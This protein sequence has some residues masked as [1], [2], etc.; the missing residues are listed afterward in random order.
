MPFYAILSVLL[1]TL[2]SLLHNLHRLCLLEATDR[3]GAKI[4]MDSGN[5]GLLS[6]A[7]ATFYGSIRIRLREEP[8]P[9]ISLTREEYESANTSHPPGPLPH[10]VKAAALAA[11]KQL[12]GHYF[13]SDRD[14]KIPLYLFIRWVVLST[15]LRS[16]FDPATPTNI[17]HTAWDVIGT[18]PM[19]DWRGSPLSKLIEPSQNPSGVFALLSTPERL[20]LVAICTEGR[21]LEFLRQARDLLAHPT[22]PESEVIRLVEGIRRSIQPI[23]F[24]HDRRPVGS[25]LFQNRAHEMD[26]RIPVGFLPPSDC[27]QDQDGS[28]I[29]WL[30]KAQPGQL[31]CGGE[32]WLVHATAI[33]LSAIVTGIRDRN[34]AVDGDD[35][36]AWEDRVLRKSRV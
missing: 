12:I 25:L 2:L 13:G 22:S 33:T 7:I 29:S 14:D 3:F 16:F 34:L 36:E 31:G 18:Q 11:T 30:H 35:S 9:N 20:I 5:I 10:V 24:I 15:F 26:V 28:C 19:G 32:G 17:E 27:I 4:L 6:I 1:V 21:D 23:Q 8:N